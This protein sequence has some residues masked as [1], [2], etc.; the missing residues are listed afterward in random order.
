MDDDRDPNIFEAVD[1]LSNMAEMDLEDLK[2]GSGLE[3]YKWL[4]PNDKER[5][6]NTV[7]KNFRVVHSYLKKVYKGS[8]K[9]FKDKEMQKGVKSV[10]TLAQ[11]AAK[12][13][14]SFS[15]IFPEGPRI[16]NL[17]ETKEFNDLEEFYE[18]KII[19][20]FHEALKMEEEW[21]EEL[22]ESEA[23]VFNIQKRGLK[24]L[25]MVIR[26][27]DYELF[28]I[29][30]E[31]GGPFYSVSLKRHI[32]LV[33]D[34]DFLVEQFEGPD[35]L[36]KIRVLSDEL[37]YQRAIQIKNCI[38]TVLGE[39]LEEGKKAKNKNL[40]ID[41]YHIIIMLCY[42]ANKNN[43][44]MHTGRKCC[45]EYFLNFIEKFRAICNSTYYRNILNVDPSKMSKYQQLSY[46]L[47]VSIGGAIYK[48]SIDYTK[49]LNFFTSIA[50][51]IKKKATEKDEQSLS[52]S[53][54]SLLIDTHDHLRITLNKYPNG[55]LF[56]IIDLLTESSLEN[57]S[58]DPY[59]EGNICEEMFTFS[60][61]R[62]QCK[63]FRLPCPTS[64]S[65]INEVTVIPEF[66]NY[67][68]EKVRDGKQVL[69]INF[70]ELTSWQ[71]YE[72]AKTIDG[73][74][75]LGEFSDI[76][77]VFSFGKDSDFYN[78]KNDFF[79]L[80]SP[81]DFMEILVS[82]MTGGV[83]SGVLFPKTMNQPKEFIAKAIKLIH[84][85]CLGKKKVL[86]R[87]NRID[88]IEILLQL[89]MIKMA[90]DLSVDELLILSKDGLDV[91][92]GSLTGLYLLLFVL[93]KDPEWKDLDHDRILSY[94]F[95]PTFI[96]RERPVDLQV[97][98]K[99]TSAYSTFSS[100]F[101]GHE[102][103]S[104]KK[105]LTLFELKSSPKLL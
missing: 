72:R 54:A 39:W 74:Q 76:L 40:T 86:S 15:H 37:A 24:N 47:F 67:L 82:Q 19:T 95:L 56:K 69:I 65:V 28:Y 92:C 32:K 11:E 25:E 30:K 84:E 59:L 78:Q 26:D 21:E 4:D 45:L 87:K 7:K 31:G 9:L 34:F 6:I 50:S 13:I 85:H 58:F 73:L 70:Q 99:I 66:V 88:M 20:R 71:E 91:A 63:V 27:K 16:Q 1:N 83:Q 46:L 57:L 29:S 44:V 90:V 98:S 62:K 35:P 12:N 68:N 5:T 3:S 17:K 60:Y 38:Q 53:P 81:G 100:S 102:A 36:L 94:M 61:Q 55:P 104:L 51:E 48:S 96:H 49:P 43:L 52:Y 8:N 80:S 103:A 89:L 10:I 2:R 22:L 41:V 105:F 14:D 42:A 97:L 64:Q 93:Q 77:S 33:S 75:Y 101:Q 18:K 79:D 23:E